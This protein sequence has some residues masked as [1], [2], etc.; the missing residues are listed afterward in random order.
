MILGLLKVMFFLAVL[1]IRLL[2]TITKFAA[3]LIVPI[4]IL[5]GLKMMV[6]KHRYR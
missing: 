3:I 2:M 1:P 6:M 4:I 5:K